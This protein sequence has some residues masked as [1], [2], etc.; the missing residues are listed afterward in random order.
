MY[1]IELNLLTNCIYRHNLTIISY[2]IPPRGAEFKSLSPPSSKKKKKK[3]CKLKNKYLRL[4]QKK[5]KKNN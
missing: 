4:P 1:H 3:T 5:K 2:L